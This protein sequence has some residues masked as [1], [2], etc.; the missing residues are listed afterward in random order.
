MHQDRCAET[1]GTQTCSLTHGRVQYAVA[2]LGVVATDVSMI[3]LH[4]PNKATILYSI[5]WSVHSNNVQA[6]MK[7]PSYKLSL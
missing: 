5:F 2:V 4:I 3:A 7:F 6:G 1:R